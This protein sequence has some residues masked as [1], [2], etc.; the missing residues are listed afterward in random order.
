MSNEKPSNPDPDPAP[1][2]VE[3]PLPYTDTREGVA[4]HIVAVTAKNPEAG[5]A[6]TDNVVRVL[7][8]WAAA[9][10]KRLRAEAEAIRAQTEAE[11]AQAKRE[12]EAAQF[13][14]E[15]ERR[16]ARRQDELARIA[17]QD[18]RETELVLE[19]NRSMFMLILSLITVTALSGSIALALSEKVV[20]PAVLLCGSIGA[21]GLGMLGVLISRRA[22]T[23]EGVTKLFEALAGRSRKDAQSAESGAPAPAAR[24]IT[25]NP[26]TGLRIT[27]TPLRVPPTQNAPSREIQPPSASPPDEQFLQDAPEEK[28]RRAG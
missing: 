17:A 22:V 25:E 11:Q 2:A 8:T 4:H 19:R 28:R 3:A 7:E 27:P 10:E 15:S 14:S 20:V 6:A 18:Q 12:S 21:V 9:E 1:S 16:E 5:K 24:K 13:A 26:G 23:M